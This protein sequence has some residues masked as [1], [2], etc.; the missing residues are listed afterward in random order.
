[1][2][3]NFFVIGVTTLP[4]CHDVDTLGSRHGKQNV[5]LTTQSETEDDV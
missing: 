3:R 4:V 5:S 2:P 1:M